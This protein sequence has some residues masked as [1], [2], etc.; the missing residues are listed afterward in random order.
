MLMLAAH[1]IT[2]LVSPTTGA[3][4]SSYKTLESLIVPT[5]TIHS[6]SNS[7][8]LSKANDSDVNLIETEKVYF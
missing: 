3:L 8:I 7:V 1:V 6:S 2:G 5:S 4:T